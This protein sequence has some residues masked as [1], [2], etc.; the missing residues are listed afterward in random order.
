MTQKWGFM[1]H[2]FQFQENVTSQSA[3][4][5]PILST[6]IFRILSAAADKT[7]SETLNDSL[8]VQIHFLCLCQLKDCA[9]E[10]K[11]SQVCILGT[12][13]SGRRSIEIEDDA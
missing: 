2:G 9:A 11:R 10:P 1:N 6:T 13:A 5:V 7:P 12:L 4:F 8:I 3:V